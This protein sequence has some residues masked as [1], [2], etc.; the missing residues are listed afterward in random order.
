MQGCVTILFFLIVFL[1]SS[2]SVCD[3]TLKCAC[4][5]QWQK[6]SPTVKLSDAVALILRCVSLFSVL[7]PCDRGK[8][9]HAG[10]PVRVRRGKRAKNERPP[11]RCR[12]SDQHSATNLA[13]SR[14]LPPVVQNFNG[15]SDVELRIAMPDKNALTVRVRKNSTTDQVYQVPSP[16]FQ[17]HR[18][19]SE[20]HHAIFKPFSLCF[21]LFLRQWWWSWGWTVRQRAILLCLRSSTTPSV[22]TDVES[23]VFAAAFCAWKCPRIAVMV[24]NHQTVQ[25]AHSVHSAPCITFPRLAWSKDVLDMNLIIQVLK[26]FYLVHSSGHTFSI[27]S[28]R[29][30]W[31]QYEEVLTIHLRHCW[32]KTTCIW[33]VTVTDT[34]ITRRYNLRMY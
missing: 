13:T 28:A 15:V 24:H 2:G 19:M 33:N 17:V 22:R 12:N 6:H 26:P 32:L 27:K 21:A 18:L 4:L 30:A 31:Q 5:N 9:R 1:N 10:V 11:G 7:R 8:R 34:G 16:A 29:L 14:L 20:T 25:W 23:S 3:V